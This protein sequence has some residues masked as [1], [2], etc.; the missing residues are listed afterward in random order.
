MDLQLEQRVFFFFFFLGVHFGVPI[1]DRE[2]FPFTSCYSW[3]R[4]RLCFGVGTV[5]SVHRRFSSVVLSVNTSA[6]LFGFSAAPTSRPDSELWYLQR[7]GGK[8]ENTRVK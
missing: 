7:D 3:T 1:T 4:R 6:F 2:D 8:E 5:G